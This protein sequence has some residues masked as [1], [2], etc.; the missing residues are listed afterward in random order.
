MLTRSARRND[1]ESP[2][3]II[4]KKGQVPGLPVVEVLT[5]NSYGSEFIWTPEG[6]LN[7]VDYALEIEV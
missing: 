6:L 5:R 7:G 4:L 2:V 1:T 3:S